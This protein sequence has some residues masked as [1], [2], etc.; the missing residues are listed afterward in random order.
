MTERP[1]KLSLINLR[2]AGPE[3]G[4][5][6]GRDRKR[7]VDFIQENAEGIVGEWE[8]F[9]R[10]LLP[11]S[12]DMSPLALR[13]HIYPILKFVVSDII[14]PQTKQ[15]Q[16]EKSHGKK[17]KSHNSVAAEAHAALRLAGGFDIDQMVSEY[18]A[19]RASV[20]KLWGAVNTDMCEEDILDLTRFN[21]AIDQVL[22]ESV[23]HYTREV[24]AAKHLF[25]GILGHDL[26]TPLGVITM[27]ADLL[28]G[29]GP[30]NERQEMLASQIRESASRSRQIVSDLLDVTRAR[31]GAGLPVNRASMDMGFVSQQLVEEMRTA[32][33]GRTITLTIA[34]DTKGEWDKAR[35]GQVFTNLIG[36][37]IQYSFAGTSV[38]VSVQGMDDEIVLSVH[39]EGKPIPAEKIR[40]IFDPLSRAVTGIGSPEAQNLGLGL[41][42]AKDIAV[43]HGGSISVISTQEAGTTFTIKLPRLPG[44]VSDA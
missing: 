1:V 3:P 36:N 7:L 24:D 28:F 38:D 5:Q 6:D 31:F 25:L 13:D 29:V 18:R 21:E 15:E 12:V 2:R 9:A 23:G 16:I 33:P 40:M 42:I 34:G 26:R 30:L 43:S 11:A 10:T 41:Y 22:A 14:S 39:N 19:L 17:A 44:T 27:S 37:A 8:A 20:I 32:Y 35:I 4:G